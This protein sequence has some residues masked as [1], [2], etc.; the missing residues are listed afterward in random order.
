MRSTNGFCQ[1]ERGAVSTLLYSQALDPSLDSVTIDAIA[2]TY[3][4]ARRGIKWKRFHD[5]LGCPSGGGMLGH[6]EVH[7]FAT[8][9]TE[10][11]EHIENTKRGGRH[12]EEIHRGQVRYVIFE[13][14]PPS[15]RRRFSMTG[16]V[17]R[18]RGLRDLN[19]QLEQFS[20]DSWC[21]PSNVRRLHF[22]DEISYFSIDRRSAYAPAPTF[23]TPIASKAFSVPTHDGI[24]VQCVQHR[25][26]S[27][28]ILC[29]QNPE[30]AVKSG[31]PR[32]LH[33]R[34]EHCELLAQCQILEGQS[35]VRLE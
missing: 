13:K 3:Q 33:R 22:M 27:V 18:N 8:V 21:A 9:M 17:L 15:L 31:R 24:R 12:G 20:M 35:S 14:S 11:Y 34:L 10:D 25:P 30:Q 29:E 5:L 19:A 28:Y 6:V 4:I 7:D 2:V 32:T 16:H 26:P 1:G 23:P